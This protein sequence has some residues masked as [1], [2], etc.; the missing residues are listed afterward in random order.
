MI[1]TRIFNLSGFYFQVYK[2][3]LRARG[4]ED[5]DAAQKLRNFFGRFFSATRLI[6][7]SWGS[8][9][10]GSAMDTVNHEVRGFP[11]QGKP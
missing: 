4:R 1:E 2:S 9:K 8:E 5:W 3:T 6:F 7:Y 10:N 11:T